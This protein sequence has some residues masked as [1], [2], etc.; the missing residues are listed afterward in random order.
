[1]LAA[2]TVLVLSYAARTAEGARSHATAYW[3]GARDI[4]YRA[5]A[6][7]I[8]ARTPQG[9]RFASVEV[10]TLA[11]Y[12]GLRAFDIGMLVTNRKQRPSTPIRWVVLDDNYLGLAP[13]W[14]ALGTAEG[15]APEPF[16]A[17]LYAVPVDRSYFEILHARLAH[18]RKVHAGK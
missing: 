5:V 4:V 10:G 7:Q 12:S 13:P 15:G 8:R 17:H 3:S 18:A 1:M 9:E 2:G 16:R 6:E 11:Y 14:P